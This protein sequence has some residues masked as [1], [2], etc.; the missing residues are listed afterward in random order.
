MGGY[1]RR[2]LLL[3]AL[4]GLV[5]A[6]VLG[7]ALILRHRLE[8]RLVA[9]EPARVTAEPDLVALAGDLARPAFA[10]HCAGC[11]GADGKGDRAKGAPDLTDAVWLYDFGR[12]SDIEQTILYGIRAGLGKS[13]NITDMPAFGRERKLTPDEIRD[14]AAFVRSLGGAAADPA[15]LERG[16]RIFEDKGVCY[17]CHGQ[18]ADGNPDYGAPAFTTGVWLYGGDAETVYRSIYDGRHGRCPAWIGTLSPVAIRA[19][20]VMLYVQSH[21]KASDGTH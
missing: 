14:V 11:H 10:A 8:A 15:V 16:R 7:R 6:G 13:R 3:L 12:V 4:A 5:L 1:R 2:P 20:A 21:G 9:A 18:A 17:D 19:L